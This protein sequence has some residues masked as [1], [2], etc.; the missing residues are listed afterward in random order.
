VATVT[1]LNPQLRFYGPYQTVCDYWNYFWTYNAE[2]FSENVASGTSQRALLNSTAGPPSQTGSTGSTNV[3]E[4]ANG[5]NYDSIPAPAKSRGD[6]EHLHESNYGAAVD[7]HGTAD[8]ESGQRGY[9]NGSLAVA[10]RFLDAEGHPFNLVRD[11]HFPGNQ[12]PTFAGRSQVPSGETFTREPQT[13][14]RL[15]PVLTTGI[16]GG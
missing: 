1:T 10:G 6:K 4:P 7:N 5:E 15:P 9:L 16:Y 12:G 8:C 3:F 13:G 2:H 11:P 14:G